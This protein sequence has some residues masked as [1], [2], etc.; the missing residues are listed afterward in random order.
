M[1]EMAREAGNSRW[2][3]L[4]RMAVSLID[5]LKQGSVAN[6]G[7]QAATMLAIGEVL[8]DNVGPVCG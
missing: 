6:D 5:R 1:E 3:Q 8:S 2:E 4:A 7:A